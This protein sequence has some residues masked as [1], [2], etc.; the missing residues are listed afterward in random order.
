MSKPKSV[1]KIL[2]VHTNFMESADGYDLAVVEITKGY[3]IRL[4]ARVNMLK[5]M[6][7]IDG[8]LYEMFFWDG[9]AS[10]Y[11]SETENNPNHDP[12]NISLTVAP[13]GDEMPTECDQCVVRENEVQWCAYPKHSE[14][15]EI[16]TSA[17]Q[18]S[19]IEKIAKGK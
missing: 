11:E 15:I 3:A 18:V 16:R 9:S 12:D 1:T 7:K 13:K 10:Y 14:G 5:K 6:R 2:D 19:E 4:L 17:V 8:D